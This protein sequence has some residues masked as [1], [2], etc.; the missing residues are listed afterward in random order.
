[1]LSPGRRARLALAVAL[2]VTLVALGIVLTRSPTAVAGSDGV[3][4]ALVATHLHRAGRIG[5]QPAGT[6]PQ[7]TDAIRVSLA[8]N[9]GPS[10][11]VRVLAGPRTVTA[12]ERAPGW[13]TTDTV[14]VPVGRVARTIGAATLCTTIGATVEPIQVDG[15]LTPTGSGRTVPRLRA[16]YLRPGTSSW[17]SLIASIAAD[18]GIE[19]APSGAWSAYLVIALMLAVAT[20]A[21]SVLL[22]QLSDD[23]GA[24]GPSRDIGAG[25]LARIPRAAWLC[26]LAAVLSAV[27]WSLVTPPFQAPDEPA[28]FAYTQLLA[29]TGEL[30]VSSSGLYSPQEE[31]ALRGL[32][33]QEVQFS[34]EDRTIS[35][36]SQAQELS[37]DL[38]RRV[39][40]VGSGNAGDA[41]SE[42]PLYYALEAIPYYL[43]SGGTLLVRLE[44]MRLLGALMAGVSALFTFLFVRESLP[45]VPWAWAVGGLGAAL[46]PLLGF[47]SGTLTPDAMLCAVCAVVFYLLARMFRRGLT[48]RLAIVL[49]LLVAVGLLTKLSF[50]GLAPGLAAGV[51]LSAS[52]GARAKRDLARA[53]A[54]PALA[55]SPALVCVLVALLGHQPALGIASSTIHALGAH[56]PLELISYVWQTY[57]PRLP[58]MSSFFPGISTLRQLW[59]ARVVGDYGWLDTSFPLWVDSAALVPATL[60]GALALG[61]ALARRAALRRRLPEL[62]TY[63]AMGVG[64]MALVGIYAFDARVS[65]GA[66]YFQ[67]RYLLPLLPLAGACLALAARG[68]GRRWG[69]AAGALIVALL[70]AHDIFAQLQVV[71]RFYG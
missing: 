54:V 32:H 36:P 64:L 40:G 17:L 71:A 26:A 66:T 3:S 52:G 15:V 69:P 41:A 10:V 50:L 8:A 56:S 19:H 14:T 53:A 2:A 29:E 59:F 22:G 28:H 45:A 7:G 37:E 5:C 42:P 58:G 21:V 38:S 55:L 60:I 67:P 4:D 57:L 13:G 25:R 63:L 11:R 1:M 33:Q 9:V 39:S 65:E 49:G 30:P 31:L 24:A 62:L 23:R 43:G 44:L 27:C 12:G 68:A 70:L 61:A 46:T 51:V 34:P 16:E 47:T 18:I 35:T 6:V 48:P 20:L